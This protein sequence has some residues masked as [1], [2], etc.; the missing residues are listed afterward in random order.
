M[1]RRIPI[2]L[3]VHGK[4]QRYHDQLAF[5]DL[6][7]A[8]NAIDAQITLI[9]SS[10][11]DADGPIRQ[12]QIGRVAIRLAVDD[13]RLNAQFSTGADNAKRDLTAIRD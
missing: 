5:G 9:G 6:R 8:Y 10:G 3:A 2:G 1:V 11:T 4:G 13:R 7:R 12:F